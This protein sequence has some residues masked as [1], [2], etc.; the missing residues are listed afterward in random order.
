MRQTSTPSSS[1]DPEDEEHDIFLFLPKLSPFP[2]VSRYPKDPELP[3]KLRRRQLPKKRERW[4]GGGGK[5]R[6]WRQLASMGTKPHFTRSKFRRRTGAPE[7]ANLK[8]IRNRTAD[9]IYKNIK[10]LRSTI[11]NKLNFGWHLKFSLGA[12]A[13]LYK[14]FTKLKIY[15][16]EK[17]KVNGDSSRRREEEAA[18]F[19]LRSFRRNRSIEEDPYCLGFRD[20]DPCGQ[21]E[22]AASMRSW[23]VDLRI[24]SLR[25]EFTDP[26]CLVPIAGLAGRYG[27]RKVQPRHPVREGAVS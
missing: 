2:A 12:F 11:N 27:R 24:V 21:P 4:E 16:N 13:I 3:G 17:N 10:N 5:G 25:A 8:A 20:Q 26:F 15:D 18:V 22:T 6:R 14:V 1:S 19:S 7:G 9:D 23:S